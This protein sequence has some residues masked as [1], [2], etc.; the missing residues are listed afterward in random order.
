MHHPDSLFKLMSCLKVIKALPEAPSGLLNR[1]LLP[2]AK[3]KA[4][5]FPD[6]QQALRLIIGRRSGVPL[7]GP[8]G[9]RSMSPSLRL[10]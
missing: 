3:Q 5:S 1:L 9:S 2:L 8:L 4:T 10:A 6:E 7:G